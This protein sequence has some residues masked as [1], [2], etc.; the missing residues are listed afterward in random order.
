MAVFNPQVAPTT[1]PNYMGYSK[2]TSQPQADTS[3]ETL[4]KGIGDTISGAVKVADLGIKSYLDNKVT[5]DVD[6]ERDLYTANLSVTRNASGAFPLPTDIGDRPGLVDKSAV[7]P[8][9]VSALDSQV[10]GLVAA[11]EAN[12]ISNTYY[13]GRLDAIAKTYRAQWPGY[14][15]HIDQKISSLTGVTPANAYMQSIVADLNK[16]K[17]AKDD[18]SKDARVLLKGLANDGNVRAAEMYA[19]FERKEIDPA[20]VIK[21]VAEENQFKWNLARKDAERKTTTMTRAETAESF[22]EDKNIE[23][24]KIVSDNFERIRDNSGIGSP[25]AVL[26]MVNKHASGEVVRSQQD[27]DR[28]GEQFTA[29]RNEARLSMIAAAKK[30]PRFAQ[31]DP[32]KINEL[33]D[34][35]LAVFD[36]V[37]KAISEKNYA[38]ADSAARISKAETEDHNRYLR[39]DQ[40][41]RK[42]LDTSKALRDAGASDKMIEGV[43]VNSLIAGVKPDFLV[44]HQKQTLQ[45]YDIRNPKPVIQQIEEG[46]ALMRQKGT[47]D[48]AFFRDKINQINNITKK[49]IPDN[50]KYNLAMNYFGP[51]NREMINKFSRD[52][53]DPNT[54][55]AVTTQNSVFAKMTNPEVV[56]EVMRLGTQYPDLKQNY[57]NWVGTTFGEVMFTNEIKSLKDVHL[58][59]GTTLA[60]DDGNG[61]KNPPG[62]RIKLNG[63]DVTAGESTRMMIGSRGPNTTPDSG[64]LM[65][66]R[67]VVKRLNFGL[68]SMW[69]VAKETGQPVNTFLIRSMLKVDPN[70]ATRTDAPI[71]GMDHVM[72]AVG[73]PAGRALQ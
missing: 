35:H 48:P 23:F 47:T 55:K 2:G 49:D 52:G 70:F 21:F 58:P 7:V 61:G 66:V 31:M 14:R 65:Q 60:Y 8:R 64:A 28:A 42:F 16:A 57:M 67:D 36:T 22:V 13:Y 46:E 30:D 53:I 17:E 38:L 51:G 5:A 33:A 68:G 72:Q 73:H 19:R 54:G 37:Q 43:L 10:E 34:H 27:I 3:Y 15:E 18:E 1:D 71:T 12:K 50:L 59:R 45:N 24:A 69:N 11:R 9:E 41:T 29:W 32:S 25:R 63:E 6:A 26:D 62:F 56:K 20:S 39:G 4:F 44:L 40:N